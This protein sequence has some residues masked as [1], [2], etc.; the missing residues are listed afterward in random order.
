VYPN[1]SERNDFV[2]AGQVLTIP[3]P[4]ADAAFIVSDP[5]GV[6]ALIAVGSR[7]PFP[8]EAQVQAA[9]DG[10]SDGS[11]G[12]ASRGVVRAGSYLA[13]TG[14]DESSAKGAMAK[15]LF[16]Q[17]SGAAA[18]RGTAARVS[19]E[20]SSAA[21]QSG[22]GAGD[23]AAS[24]GVPGTPLVDPA[25]TPRAASTSG[26]GGLPVTSLPAGAGDSHSSLAR[27]ACFYTTLP[28]V[29]RAH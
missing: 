9:F 29:S 17:Y 18:G 28:R 14:L 22:N 4:G 20:P 26:T 15:G 1:R 11:R 8:D 12:L 2:R 25:D 27:A 13:Q 3:E 24:G 6:D 7:I 5:C 21:L 10:A 16:V 23:A 19:G